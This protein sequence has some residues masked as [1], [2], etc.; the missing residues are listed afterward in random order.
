LA[1]ATVVFMLV[2]GLLLVALLRRRDE[3]DVVAN[4]TRDRLLVVGGG[5]VVPLIILVAVYFLTL[6]TMAALADTVGSD[7]V[8]IKVIGHQW[9][10]EVQYPNQDITTA[11]EIH[12][13]VGEP[14][15]IEVESADV[16]HSIWVPEIHGK[17]DMIPG[18]T[19]RITLQ[20]DE[21]GVY[22]GE[23]AEFCGIQHAKMAFIL[24]ASPPDRFAAWLNQQSQPAAEP[25][26][27]Q[28]QQGQQVFLGAGCAQCHTIKGTQATGTLG[29]DLT[30][31]AGRR[32]LAAGMLPN[33]R[34]NLG[35]WVIDPQGIKPGNLMPPTN[36]SGEE[37]QALLAYLESLE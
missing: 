34:G 17:I 1:I 2:T 9:W 10:W 13:P 19:N 29:P 11:N 6:N 21:A 16:I 5:I 32:S 8:V 37:L 14:I 33:N 12:I 35:G 23:C 25:D 24:V 31:L 4:E 27:P 36:L 15:R 18:Q 3:A 26:D 30:R 22:F 7:D 20:A 28:T